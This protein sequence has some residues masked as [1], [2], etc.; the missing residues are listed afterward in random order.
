MQDQPRW[1]EMNGD[2]FRFG[3]IGYGLFGAHHAQAIANA[4]GARLTAIAVRSEVSQAAAHQTHPDAQIHGD[5]HALLDSDEIDIV[6]VVPPNRLHYEIGRA[7]LEAD[8]HLL[9]EKPMALELGHCD[10]LVEL[11]L[12]R[13]IVLAIGH[14]LRL[15]SLWGGAKQLIDDG[16]I[17][18]PLHVLIKLS[19]FP[20]R[21][22]SEG[23]RYEIGHVGSWILEEPIHFFDLAR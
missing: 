20:Y 8:K 18:D 2:A 19:R 3:L 13:D 1:I 7:A 16:A 17:G 12:A 6:A 10:E 14:E 22:G 15:S 5:Y 11:A 21:Q 9:L 4:D 23:W